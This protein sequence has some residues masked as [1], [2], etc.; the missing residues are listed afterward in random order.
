MAV[1]RAGQAGLPGVAGSRKWISEITNPRRGT[2]GRTASSAS[3][4]RGGCL[5]SRSPPARMMPGRGNKECLDGLSQFNAVNAYKEAIRLNARYSRR[6]QPGVA[7]SNLKQYPRRWTHS[8]RRNALSRTILRHSASD[9][10]QPARPARRCGGFR[11]AVRLKPDG[12][13][14]TASGSATRLGRPPNRRRLPTVDHLTN[15]PP[16]CSLGS[17]RQPVVRRWWACRVSFKPD[18]ATWS[19]WTRIPSSASMATP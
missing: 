12:S 17:P 16:W 5:Q 6:V 1:G 9:P 19:T 8:R 14:G 15:D 13:D 2:W 11:E 7:C 3:S 4:Q 10:V 18:D